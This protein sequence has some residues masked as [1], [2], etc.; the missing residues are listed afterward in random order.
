MERSP[1]AG[2]LACLEEI[3]SDGDPVGGV[4]APP[5][6]GTEVGMVRGRLE[7]GGGVMGAEVSGPAE[8]VETGGRWRDF[9]KLAMT[10]SL[11]RP[12]RASMPGAGGKRPGRP[13]AALAENGVPREIER[14]LLDLG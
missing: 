12:L 6:A 7:V 1:L 14:E 4:M 11:M 10:S 3:F 5:G 2:E 8:P 9:L 13:R